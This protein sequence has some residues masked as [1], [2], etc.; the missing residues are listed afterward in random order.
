VLIEL[1]IKTLEQ[2]QHTI[3]LG[4]ESKSYIH[5]VMFGMSLGQNNWFHYGSCIYGDNSVIFVLNL[6]E[7]FISM[8]LVSFTCFLSMY[9]HSDINTP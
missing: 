7:S 8:L 5:E 1:Y 4:A 9:K 2:V 6:M 3:Q